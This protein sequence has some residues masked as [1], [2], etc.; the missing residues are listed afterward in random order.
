MG[1]NTITSIDASDYPVSSVVVFKQQA[2][3]TRIFPVKLNVS[4]QRQN[5][6]IGD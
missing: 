2:E 1:S 3:V 6:E 4:S 5:A